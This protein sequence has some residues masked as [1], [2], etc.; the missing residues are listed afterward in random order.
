MTNKENQPQQ[1]N[2]DSKVD[3]KCVRCGKR[4][5][6]IWPATSQGARDEENGYCRACGKLGV[7]STQKEEKP[8]QRPY[9]YATGRLGKELSIMQPYKKIDGKVVDNEKFYEY[10]G[11]ERASEPA[12]NK[13]PEKAA[14]YKKRYPKGKK[15]N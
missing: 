3:S 6:E 13:D 12:F 8:R 9:K 11:G 1:K 2:L 10:Y 4:P 5:M 7:L 15:S 14:Y